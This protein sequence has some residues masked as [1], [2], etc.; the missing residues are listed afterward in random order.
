MLSNKVKETKCKYIKV[1]QIFEF[2]RKNVVR[3]DNVVYKALISLISE[4]K[5]NTFDT[6]MLGNANFNQMRNWGLLMYLSILFV[7][8]LL[9]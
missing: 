8:I 1:L 7:P 9:I 5:I 6:M 2:C 3:Y 4:I